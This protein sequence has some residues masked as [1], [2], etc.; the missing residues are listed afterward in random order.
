ML[1]LYWS[2][3]S[4]EQSTDPLPL[5]PDP[6]DVILYLGANIQEGKNNFKDWLAKIKPTA[7]S[8]IY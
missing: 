8:E 7:F 3:G 6:T 1:L 2:F 5:T 4:M